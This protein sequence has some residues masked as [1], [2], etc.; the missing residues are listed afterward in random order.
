MALTMWSRTL[1]S[2]LNERDNFR[3]WLFYADPDYET[4]LDHLEANT[5]V[6]VDISTM[7]G[8]QVVRARQLYSILVGSLKREN[9]TYVS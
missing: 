2:G 1:L 7:D 6:P 8:P 3:A 4:S 9:H 5:S